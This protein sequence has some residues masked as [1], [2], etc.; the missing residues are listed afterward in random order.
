VVGER[1]AIANIVAK[2]MGWQLELSNPAA[3]AGNL[4]SWS[5]SDC[6]ESY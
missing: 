2:I 4:G 1:Q 5:G 6:H 3:L